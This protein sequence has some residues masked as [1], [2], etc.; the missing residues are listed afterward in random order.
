MDD[1]HWASFEVVLPDG[2]T[3]TL[4]CDLNN[5]GSIDSIIDY[6]NYSN[7]KLIDLR[8]FMSNEVK[9]LKEAKNINGESFFFVA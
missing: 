1:Y 7:A 5:S 2:V 8:N 6:L 4:C 9:K 3:Q